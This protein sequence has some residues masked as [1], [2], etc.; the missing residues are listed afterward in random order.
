VVLNPHHATMGLY[1][2]AYWTYVLPRR[3]GEH[4]ARSLTERCLPVGAAE[5]VRIGLADRVLP[6]SPATFDEAV[7]DYATSLASSADLPEL[8]VAKRAVRA[9]DERRR[10]LRSHRSAELIEMSA[11]ILDDRHGF[12]DARRSFLGTCRAR[13]SVPRAA[14]G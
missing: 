3:V 9:A 1:G 10:P 4:A 12:A 11:D 2:S 5:A 6:G 14:A 7:H 8:M 13:A